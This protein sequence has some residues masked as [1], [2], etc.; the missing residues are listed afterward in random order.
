MEHLKASDPDLYQAMENE[1]EAST[2]CNIE[3]IASCGELC[4]K[5]SN[6]SNGLGTYEQVRQKVIQ[7]NGIMVAV[8]L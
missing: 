6:G 5:S 7:A 4:F 1:K 2:R 8:N 3:L